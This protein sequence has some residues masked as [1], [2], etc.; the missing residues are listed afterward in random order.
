MAE[1]PILLLAAG[2][3]ERMGQAKQLLPWGKSTLIEHQIRVLLNTGHP[4]FVV[5]GCRS[6]QIQHIVESFPVQIVINEEWEK[7][8]GT[9]IAT[10]VKY[11]LQSP[12]PADG[13][14]VVLVDQPL[15]P[16]AHYQRMLDTF[17]PGQ[18]RILASRSEGGIE[19]VPALF[20]AKYF[21]E[22][23]GLKGAGG[24]RKIIRAHDAKV[25]HLDCEE[26]GEDLDTPEDYQRLYA[27]DS[28][29]D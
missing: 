24:A 5:L 10:G 21:R 14:L 7:G 13:I 15:V 2:G 8:M 12:S 26:M 3:S 17:Q 23:A 22:L 25:V 18:E 16:L 29:A 1:I 19:G 11:V 6:E 9:S 28:G 4:V 20:D 27:R